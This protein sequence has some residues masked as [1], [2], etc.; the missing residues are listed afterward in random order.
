VDLEGRKRYLKVTVT[1]DTTTNGPVTV[2][3]DATVY[4]AVISAD[5]TMLGPDVAIV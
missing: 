1:P 4:K 2:A 5:A 3:M